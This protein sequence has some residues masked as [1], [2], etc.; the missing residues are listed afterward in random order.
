M[1]DTGIVVIGRNEGERLRR[2]LESLPAVPI[3]YVD[4]GSSDGSIELAESLGVATLAL[5]PAQRFTA[6]RAR[7]E[8]SVALLARHRGLAYLQT[9]DGDCFLAPDWIET[10]RA[11]LEGADASLGALY[12]ALREL[13]PERSVYNWL[14]D[15]EWAS[16][17][18]PTPYFGGL[19]LFRVACFPLAARYDSGLIAGEERDLSIRLGSQGWRFEV[20]AAPMA[21]HDAEMTRFGQWWVRAV[22][23]G[24]ALTALAR[25]HAGNPNQDFGRRFLS[26]LFWGGILPLSLMLAIAAAI[27]KGGLGT[28]LLALLLVAGYLIQVFRIARKSAGSPAQRLALGGF[29]MLSKTAQCVGALRAF[30]RQPR[31]IEYRAL[32]G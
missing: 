27:I 29:T 16:R 18:G 3:L 30:A 31:L 23:S 22:R 14:C 7:N 21:W 15:R 17:P 9:I 4:S 10:A 8:G 24:V 12:G 1:S 32:N 26:M 2:C 20:L 11:H 6:A 13:A 5:D 25:R 28:V 19:A